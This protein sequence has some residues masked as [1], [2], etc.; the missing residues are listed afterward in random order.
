MVEIL[1]SILPFSI[2]FTL[3]VVFTVLLVKIFPWKPR[4]RERSQKSLLRQ[5]VIGMVAFIV[6]LPIAVGVRNSSILIDG[7]NMGSFLSAMA[8]QMLP[9][10]LADVAG[11][12]MWL[13]VERMLPY[14][15]ADE[16]KEAPTEAIADT[17]TE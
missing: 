7:S 17:A 13:A 14:V 10:L 11:V 1:L 16:K 12:V 9:F 2:I 5:F 4:W 6:C 3:M 8:T 15:P